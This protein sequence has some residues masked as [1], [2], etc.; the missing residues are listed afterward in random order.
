MLKKKQEKVERRVLI[1]GALEWGMDQPDSQG[2]KFL[3][4]A[5]RTGLTALEMKHPDIPMPRFPE[6]FATE[7]LV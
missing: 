3:Q 5:A 4:V 7:P 2:K 6:N 1:G